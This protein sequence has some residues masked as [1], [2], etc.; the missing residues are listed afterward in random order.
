MSTETEVGIQEVIDAAG[1]AAEA[2]TE[3]QPMPLGKVSPR[4]VAEQC[5]EIGER[6]VAERRWVDACYAHRMACW[7]WRKVV[8][9]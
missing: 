8:D 4:L 3:R 7:Y 9:A 1:I 5:E 6:Y 2:I